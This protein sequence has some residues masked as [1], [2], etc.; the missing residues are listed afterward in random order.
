MLFI[1]PTILTGELGQRQKATP[2]F[3]LLPKS[4]PHQGAHFISTK[5]ATPFTSTAP[6]HWWSISCLA[7]AA[8]TKKLNNSREDRQRSLCRYRHDQMQQIPN[9]TPES[10]LSKSEHW[11]FFVTF[12]FG[13][14]EAV[15]TAHAVMEGDRKESDEGRNRNHFALRGKMGLTFTLQR[16]LTSWMQSQETTLGEVPSIQTQPAHRCL[17]GGLFSGL[18]NVPSPIPSSMQKGLHSTSKRWAQANT[19]SQQHHSS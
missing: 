11:H 18:Q 8:A 10:Y 6:G 19:K 2:G 13:K 7:P 3:F 17:S 16:N 15:T 9:N 14:G 12:G 5:K 4:L 1:H